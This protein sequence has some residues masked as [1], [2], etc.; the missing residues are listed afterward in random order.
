MVTFARPDKIK[1]DQMRSVKEYLLDEHRIVFLQGVITS[2]ADQV[3]SANLILALAAH[4]S[5]PIKMFIT[6]PG[7]V[8]DTAMMIYD[9]MRMVDVPIITVG[10]YCASAAAIL[11]AAGSKR[12]LWPQAKMMLHLPSGQMAGNSAE[13]QIQKEEMDKT[14]QSMIDALVECGVSKTP[15]QILKDINNG[16]KWF[17]AKEAIAYGMADGVVT[18]EL[19]KG[20]LKKRRLRA[21]RQV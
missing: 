2:G 14:K 20:W 7:G 21:R 13:L 5:A 11:M 10:R 9:T 18:K 17:N 19:L 4:S 3:D 1:D 12:Y 6:S 16:D 15:R 8:V